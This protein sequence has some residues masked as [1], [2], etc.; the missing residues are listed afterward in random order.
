MIKILPKT[1]YKLLFGVWISSV[2]DF[3][4]F[5]ILLN[6]RDAIFDFKSFS[7]NIALDY[8]IS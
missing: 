8:L 3:G 2:Y 1:D 6:K 4:S 7:Y 5:A